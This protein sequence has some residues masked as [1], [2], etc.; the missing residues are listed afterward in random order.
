M[1]PYLPFG[2]EHCSML[3]AAGF[4]T[5]KRQ[6]IW[7]PVSCYLIEHPLHGYILVDTGWSRTMSPDGVYDHKAQIRSL[8]SPVLYMMN[9]G[10]VEKGQAIDEQLRN[11][12]IET[13][14]LRAVLLTH[15][16]CDHANG[17]DGVSDAQQILVSRAELFPSPSFQ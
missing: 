7:L 11:L 3:K 2:G 1:S 16:D 17:L 12:G 10:V 9:Q 5:P 8:G 4:T 15:L 14:E 13:R 6:W